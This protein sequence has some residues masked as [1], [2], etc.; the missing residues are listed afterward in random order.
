MDGYR[1]ALSTL[2]ELLTGKPQDTT[3]RMTAEEMVE[4]IVQK[5]YYV[6]LIMTTMCDGE[7]D[8]YDM[9]FFINFLK[10][11]GYPIA[12]EMLHKAKL[13]AESYCREEGITKEKTSGTTNGDKI[14]QMN[15]T[16]LARLITSINVC[17]MC[18]NA[19]DDECGVGA[20][21]VCR[22][23]VEEW[24]KRESED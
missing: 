2:T 13:D 19:F 15:N 22:E 5:L 3:M 7:A 16:Q 4:D 9:P 11:R 20:D 1:H 10:D 6:S 8:D 21:C 18:T 12:P 14:R 24:L 17:G 23:G